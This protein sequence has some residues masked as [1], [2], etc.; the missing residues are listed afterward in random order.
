MD[1]WSK[2]QLLRM[3]RGGNAPAKQFFEQRFGSTYKTMTIP[4]KVDLPPLNIMTIKQ[5]C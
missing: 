5:S 3:E 2:E 4:E 1:R